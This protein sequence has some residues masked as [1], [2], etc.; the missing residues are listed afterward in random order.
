MKLDQFEEGDRIRLGVEKKPILD[1]IDS[2]KD[3]IIMPSKA[4]VSTSL[5]LEPN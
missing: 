4:K 1:I 5:S 3:R 2:K